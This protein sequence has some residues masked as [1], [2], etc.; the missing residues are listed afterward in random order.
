MGAGLGDV[1][2]ELWH[3]LLLA[4]GGFLFTRIRMKVLVRNLT[5]GR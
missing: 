3:L 2:P 1:L 5:G 4:V